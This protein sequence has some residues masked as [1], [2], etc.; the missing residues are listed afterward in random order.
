MPKQGTTTTPA[1]S[2]PD[3]EAALRPAYR[4][5]D[6]ITFG[7]E[8]NIRATV[9]S[10]ELIDGVLWVGAFACAAFQ[11]PATRVVCFEPRRRGEANDAP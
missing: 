5:G 1:N 7:Y 6:E 3:N 9:E 8:G 10:F 4:V 2:P 11:V